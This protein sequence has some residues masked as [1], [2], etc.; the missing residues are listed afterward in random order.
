MSSKAEPNLLIV[1]NCLSLGGW[2]K[3]G[4]TV[5]QGLL[6]AACTFRLWQKWHCDSG[7]RTENTILIQS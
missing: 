4:Y 3:A 1:F 5:N 6:L 2:G 7:Q